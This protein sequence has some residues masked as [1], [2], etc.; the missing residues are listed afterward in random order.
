VSKENKLGLRGSD[1]AF[2]HFDD[3]QV[4]M[5]PTGEIG[6]GFRQC[7]SLDGGRIIGAMAWVG[8]RGFDVASNTRRPKQ[9]ASPFP[10]ISHSAQTCH[11]VHRQAARLMIYETAQMKDVGRVC[12]FGYV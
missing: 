7:W 6:N 4:P 9:S 2:L 11:N 5:K 1:T 12:G 3:M 10:T 8:A